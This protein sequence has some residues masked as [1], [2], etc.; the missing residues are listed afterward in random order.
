MNVASV[1]SQ[2]V[3]D[4][5]KYRPLRLVLNNSLAGGNEKRNDCYF[6]FLI[7]PFSSKKREDR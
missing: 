3:S 1:T 7:F 6:L 4:G 5:L 2:R